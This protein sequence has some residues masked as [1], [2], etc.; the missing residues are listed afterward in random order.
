[1]FEFIGFFIL[2]MFALFGFC[3]AAHFFK[4][5]FLFPKR[6]MNSQLVIKLENETAEKQLTFAGEQYLWLGN[7]FADSVVADTSQLDTVTYLRC[8]EIARKY[9]IL[10]P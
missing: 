6:R 2:L 9:N 7:K 10:F 4:L 1:M 8:K 5:I 3:E